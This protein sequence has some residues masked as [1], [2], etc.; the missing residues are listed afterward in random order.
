MA[1]SPSRN[2]LGITKRGTACKKKT[3]FGQYCRFHASVLLD[4]DD[5]ESQ[6]HSDLLRKKQTGSRDVVDNPIHL[7]L[8]DLKHQVS[9]L[10]KALQKEKSRYKRPRNKKPLQDDDP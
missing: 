6:K 1:V 9:S 5:I 8:Q 4:D 10:E 7:Q 3:S 2:C